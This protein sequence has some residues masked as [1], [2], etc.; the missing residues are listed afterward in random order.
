MNEQSERSI[1]AEARQTMLAD[2]VQHPA[3][4]LP[5]ASAIAA[6]IYLLLLTP[7]FGG[8]TW[9]IVILAAAGSVSALSFAWL[10]GFHLSDKRD[11]ILA[12]LTEERKRL[13]ALAEKAAADRRRQDLHEALEAIGFEEGIEA[14][15]E[16]AVEYELLQSTLGR[17]E[18]PASISMA[19]VPGLADGTYLRG[20]SGLE[21]ALRLMPS[22]RTAGRA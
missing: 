22:S 2:A 16:L 7:I 14:L 8:Q 20:L 6:L 18:Q 15:D 4:L 13:K 1:E 12:K 19:S 21:H 17:Q 5:L 11:G 3:T 9:V 10:Y